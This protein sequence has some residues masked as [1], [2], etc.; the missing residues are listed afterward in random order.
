MGKNEDAS[1]TKK[2]EEGEG[3]VVRVTDNHTSSPYYLHPSDGP[4]NMITTVQLRGENYE[5][6][7]KHVQNALRTKRKLGFIDGTLVKPENEEEI[8][9]WEVVNSMLIAWIMNTI[10]STLKT[11]ISM[12]DEV[13][14]LWEDLKLQFS[15]G[16]GPRIN[17]LRSDIANC[18]QNGDSV[19]VYYGKLKKMWDELAIYKPIRTCS[20]GEMVAQLEDD[21][22]EE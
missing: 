22:N 16:N 12:V 8:E 4:G 20:C 19:M 18:K 3:G 13:K 2:I 7:A 1:K 21:R 6:W 9:Q 10:E 14:V 5:E 17:E 11:S 15:V